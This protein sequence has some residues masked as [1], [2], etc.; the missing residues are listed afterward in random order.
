MDWNTVGGSGPDALEDMLYSYSGRFVGIFLIDTAARVYLD[1]MGSLGVMFSATS[2]AA[3]SSM[4]LIPAPGAADRSDLTEALGIPGANAIY[5][6][7]VTPRESVEYLMPNHYL[8]LEGWTVHRHWPTAELRPGTATD[9]LVSRVIE[10]IRLNVGAI[11]R[12]GPIQMSLTAGRDSRMMLAASRPFVDDIAFVT[13]AIDDALGIPDQKVAKRLARL[14]GLNH[15][16]IHSRLPSPREVDLWAYRTGCMVDETRGV[17]LLPAMAELDATK[18]YLMGSGGEVGRAEY[19]QAG[20]TRV[21]SLDPER[22]FARATNRPHPETIRRAQAWLA[23]VPV[24]DA[25]TVLD[26]FQI[27]FDAGWLG[28]LLYGFPDGGSFQF[29]PYCDRQIVEAM[30]RLPAAYRFSQR[31]TEDIVA[32]EWPELAAFPYNDASGKALRA[33]KRV[34]HSLGR[35]LR[36]RRE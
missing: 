36:E 15:R 22:L 5:P 13:L 14:A 16:L 8:D 26:L 18:P 10:R 33:F 29:L 31:I 28:F 24:S 12:E 19:W 25:F 9:E 17:T 7:G 34:R 1:P 3:A 30:L 20:D 11:V 32:S 4:F 23:A 2:G 35:L 21:T 6:F 27:E